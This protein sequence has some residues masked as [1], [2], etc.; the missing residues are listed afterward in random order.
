MGIAEP[1]A[2]SY[3]YALNMVLLGRVDAIQI[4]SKR[5]ERRFR[6][7]SIQCALSQSDSFDDGFSVL[8]GT[9]NVDWFSDYVICGNIFGHA[10]LPHFL[11]GDGVIVEKGDFITV[12]ARTLDTT[13]RRITILFDGEHL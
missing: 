6:V 4:N 12:K 3:G 10:A 11:P 8:L 2:G 1:L 7:V 13:A 5:V 9:E